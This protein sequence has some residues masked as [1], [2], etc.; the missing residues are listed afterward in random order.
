M[1]IIYGN[2][3]GGGSG[4]GKTY[5]L[6]DNDGNQFTGIL[7]DELTVFTATAED[8]KIGKVAGTDSGIVT[9]THICE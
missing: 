4:L 9:G 6:E 8:I 3:V 1:S 5:L 2:I 7:V